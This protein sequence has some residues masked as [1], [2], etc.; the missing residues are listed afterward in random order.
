[1]L[2][3]FEYLRQRAFDAVLTG[4]QEAL[5]FLE[6]Q[7]TWNEPRAKSNSSRQSLNFQPGKQAKPDHTD[8]TAKDSET[9]DSDDVLRP[10]RRRGRPQEKVS[11]H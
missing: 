1:M 9:S 3:I 6:S 10:P 8:S 5:D 2:T 4:A 11:R 7:E